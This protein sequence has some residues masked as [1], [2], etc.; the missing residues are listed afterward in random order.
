MR[1]L[2]TVTS[3]DPTPVP[4]FPSRRRLLTILGLFL[5]IVSFCPAIYATGLFPGADKHNQPY[6]LIFGTVWGP[7]DKPLYG[8]K[9][10]IRKADEKKTRWEVYSD[11]HGEFAQRVPA[12]KGDYVLSA[13][14]KGFKSQDGKRLQGQEVT[15]HVEYDER[16]DT[17]LHLK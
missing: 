2:K 12:R 16:V 15:V 17:G 5:A 14:L 6:A 11:H 13:D 8:V 9:V 10:K 3:R 1:T 4:V 7:D